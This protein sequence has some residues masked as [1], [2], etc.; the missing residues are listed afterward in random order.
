MAVTTMEKE[1]KLMRYRWIVWGVL[2]LAYI[3]VFFHRLAAGVVREDLITAFAISD[4]TFANLGSTYFYAYMIMQIPSGFLADSLGARKTVTL[5][6]LLAALGSILFGWA[7]SI[8][9]AFAGR[10]MVGLGVSVVFIAILK[11]QS[12]WFKESEF[13]T[14]SGLTSLVGN[15]G[16]IIAQTPL[17]IM[18]GYL[19]WRGSFILMGVLTL[20]IAVLCWIFVRNTPSDMGLPTIAELEGLPASKAGE[21]PDLKK[22]L[23]T[24]V[25]NWR[26]WPSFF[27]FAGFFGAFVTLSGS[28][29]TTYLMKVYG[30][31]KVDASGYITFAVLGLALGSLAIGRLSDKLKKRKL[32]MIAFGAVYVLSW[33]TFVYAN[34]GQLPLAF[35]KPLLFVLGF[36][37]SAFVLGWACGKEINP[38]AI[39]GLST[40]VVNMGGF[41][42][43]AFLPVFLGQVF[44]KYGA[45]LE[46]AALYQKAFSLSVGAVVV[47]FL[48]TFLVKETG[49]RNIY[50]EVKK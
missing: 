8:A 46:A 10:L 18:V 45:S 4:T 11:V 24:V 5:G 33:V 36:S 21:R 48:F 43:A 13:G 29:G 16:G 2:A 40:S 26:T 9:L 14:M 35:I 25:S 28:F 12:Q 6:T 34:G 42:G 49:C 1:Q 27:V 22:G 17:A 47:G 23:I 50:S 37:C 39:A 32:P 31:E 19:T 44:D 7:P 15:M 30:M 3:I 38:P 41:F 20:V